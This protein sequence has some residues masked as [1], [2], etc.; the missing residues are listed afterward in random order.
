MMATYTRFRL[1]A[2]LVSVTIIFIFPSSNVY[3]QNPVIKDIIEE[4][5]SDLELED[6]DYSTFIEDLNF[7]QENPLNLNE[8]DIEKLEKLHFLTEFQIESLLNYIAQRGGMATI[9][10]LQLI[11]GFTLDVIKKMLPFV[12]V[13][14]IQ[15][16]EKIVF[17]KVLKYGRN[18]LIAETGFLLQ[19]QKGFLPDTTTSENSEPASRYAGDKMRYK[20]KYKFHYKDRVF[21]GFTAE[22]DAGEAF[23]FN[24]KL[25]GFDYYSAHFQLNDI[26]KVKQLNVGD[27]QVK[28]GQGLILWTG[29][30]S[31]KSAD[32]LNI[33]KKGQGLRYYTSTNENNFMRGTGATLK[34]GKFEFTTFFSY[35]KIDAS[36]EQADTLEN[37]EERLTALQNSGY[38]RTQTELLN[39]KVIEET[40]A[41]AR[42]GVTVKNIKLSAN[43][44]GYKY[45]LDFLPDDKPYKLYD[46][47]GN[48]NF[49]SSIDYQVFFKKIGLFGETAI[50]KN[51]ALAVQNGM[52]T[53]IVPQ[54]SFSL[55]QRYYQKD[56]QA[57][58]SN[59][60]AENSKISNE[61]GMYYGIEFHP[62]SRV[63]ISAY[64]DLYEFP[65]LKFGVDAPSSGKEY[66]VQVSYSANRWVD[67]H[68]RWKTESKSSNLTV[69]NEPLKLVTNEK[70]EQYRYHISYQASDLI[71]LRS[72]IEISRFQQDNV[73][74][75][76]Y[77]LLQDINFSFRHLPLS[78][79]T[80]YA[81]FD[82]SYNARIYA[83]END[84]LYSFSVP[85][86]AG[87]GSRVYAMIN[88]TIAD[89]ID[90]RVRYSHF[91]YPSEKNISSG[92]SEIEGNLKSEIKI[93]LVARF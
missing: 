57:Q 32:V 88:Y 16:K 37:I 68:F 72:R 10:E 30:G 93:Q 45:G 92:L 23:D 65:W 55:L 1:I 35:K 64:T 18:R 62:I 58:Y 83:Y 76:G 2:L 25:K 91:F 79:S 29:F 50:G 56:Y 74:E 36:L 14:K 34:F 90:L 19:D 22:K 81:V 39:R 7:Y 38:H 47:E 4:I 20:L 17:G 11:D 51:G 31:G 89:F 78:F 87:K 48:S 85:A 41:G 12:I 71:S 60:F 26:G 61:Q 77:L 49:N 67:M 27:F 15:E 80:R 9:Y 28:F 24:E 5:A 73:S 33:R 43:F 8:A 70:K 66:F 75:Y 42:L 86:Y 40:V 46:F 69:E 82:A 21:A 54:L 63:K 59:S 52:I 44:V 84:V 3:A 13:E 53:S 6:A